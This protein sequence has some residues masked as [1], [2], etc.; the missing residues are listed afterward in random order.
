MTWILRKRDKDANK[1]CMILEILGFI[2]KLM[3]VKHSS[4]YLLDLLCWDGAL[5]LNATSLGK[6]SERLL[7]VRFVVCYDNEQF[8]IHTRN[9]Y[10]LFSQILYQ[11]MWY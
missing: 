6:V 4:S 8:E 1:S 9:D 3:F 7:I 2:A 5:T 10:S 11:N